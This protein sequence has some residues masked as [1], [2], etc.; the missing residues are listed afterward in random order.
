MSAHEHSHP[1]HDHDHAHDHH[2]HAHDPHA[3][4][5][6]HD[7]VTESH[8]LEQALRELL[9][10]RGI[11]TAAEIH[12]QIDEQES[13]T[14]ATGSRLVAKAWSDPE[15]RRRLVADPKPAIAEALGI[16]TAGMPELRVLENT[17]EVH[18]VAV[19]TLC[20]CYPRALL[21][22]PPAW[23]KSSEYRG[24]AVREPRKV[25]SE[26]G[27]ELPEHVSIRVVDSTADL[28]YLII[29]MRPE[30]TEDYDEA[31]LAALVGRDSM[32]GTALARAAA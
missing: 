12:R 18:H 19:C 5:E 1:D 14:S 32:I 4:I 28:R 22:V 21:G 15:F 26:F 23:Y 6:D 9:I 29:P 8:I 3:P 2:D 17:P 27:L 11:F 24:R 13:R 30:G 25:L 10:E 31:A 7:T 16:D 20:S